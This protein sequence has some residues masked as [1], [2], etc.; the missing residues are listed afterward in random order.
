MRARFFN[1]V[2]VC[3]MMCLGGCHSNQG[4]TVIEDAPRESEK[5]RLPEY[6]AEPPD[7]LL[8]E[9]VRLVPKPPYKIEPLDVLFV[10]LGNPLPMEPLGGPVTVDSDGTIDL[11]AAYRGRVRV[12]GK[13]LDEA[14]GIIEKHLADVVKLQNP[15]V[16]VGLS[17]SRGA[18]QVAGPHLIRPDGTIGL[19]T[20]GSLPV[21]GLT[22]PE[23]KEAVEK[24]LEK[25]LLNPEVY[26]DVQGYNSK[27]YYLIYDGAGSG[28]SVYRLPITGNETVLDAI[29]QVNGLSPVASKDMIWM[30]RPMKRGEP[31]MRLDVDWRAVSMD[32]A[33]ETNYQ[34]MPGDRVYVDAQN[35]VKI[36]IFMAKLFAPVERV[37]GIILLGRS[38][39]QNF[40]NNNNNNNGVR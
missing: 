20:Y 7:I 4:V 30:A 10:Q 8:I 21:A 33:T 16:T 23:I 24:L 5:W 19:G 11:G 1:I 13:T 32:A 22:L 3:A 26:V 25:N 34:L 38:A 15:I 37:L 18:Q 9:G 35:L 28:Q 36:D 12:V 2:W 27:V 29:A 14:K 6:R 40:N 17:Q 39:G 31:Y